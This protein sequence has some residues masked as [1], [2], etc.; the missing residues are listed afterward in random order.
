MNN[1][2][3][4]TK[5]LLEEVSRKIFRNK[6]ALVIYHRSDLDGVASAA[7][8]YHHYKSK[9]FDVELKGW[10]YG[11]DISFNSAGADAILVA[12]VSFGN[13]HEMIMR[14]WMDDEKEVVWC[15]HHKTA[16]FDK[17]GAKTCSFVPGIREVGTAACELV[18]QY[19]YPEKDVPELIKYLSTYDVWDKTR[20]DWDDVIA[21]QYGV[22]AVVGLDVFDMGKLL[23]SG[24]DIKGLIDSGRNILSFLSNK[25]RQECDQ[26]GFAGQICGHSAVCMN[27]LEFNSTTFEYVGD[28]FDLMVP[29]AILP[30]GK[31]RFSL[32]TSNPDVDCSTI[33]KSFGGGG[34]KAAAGFILDIQDDRVGMFFKDHVINSID[35]FH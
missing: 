19:L 17:D 7:I 18:W 21:F 22:R 24:Y 1:E 15:D 28:K 34:H 4:V 10:T 13:D 27:T 32:Y 2:A 16:I 3:C 25:N 9:G 31:V 20:Y 30:N 14:K 8:A 33:A 12:D 26:F 23:Y 5:E 11:D 35:S 29:F 6:S